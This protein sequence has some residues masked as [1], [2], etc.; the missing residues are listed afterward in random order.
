MHAAV[1]AALP[2]IDRRGRTALPVAVVGAGSMGRNHA[3]V[4]SEAVAADLSVVVDVEAA[5]ARELAD[6]YGCAWSASLD[7]VLDRVAAVVVASATPTHVELAV[8]CLRAG[9]PV[10]V[11]KPLAED[12]AGVLEVLAVAEATGTPLLCGFVERF[13]PAVRTARELLAGELVHISTVRHSP[14]NPR[15]LGGVVSDLLR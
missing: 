4:L 8:R 2:R 13:N 1:P 10:L 5:R 7:E 3:R 9:L 6:H 11:E 12:P 14:H 15:A